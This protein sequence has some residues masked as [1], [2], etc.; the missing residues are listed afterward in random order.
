MALK[1]TPATLENLD[2]WLDKLEREADA[3]IH[4][5]RDQ[6]AKPGRERPDVSYTD[7]DI[8]YKQSVARSGLLGAVRAAIWNGIPADD[9][10]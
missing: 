9:E 4:A 8:R 6:G 3:E 7:V 5:L 10:E 2:K 1:R